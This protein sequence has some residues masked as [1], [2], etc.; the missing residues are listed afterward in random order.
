ML[1]HR[2]QSEGSQSFGLATAASAPPRLHRFW[3]WRTRGGDRSCHAP[4]PRVTRL[5][6]QSLL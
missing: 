6:L 5:P 4:C 3:P 1:V 2:V